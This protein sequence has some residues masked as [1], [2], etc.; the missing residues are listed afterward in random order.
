MQAQAE[1]Q[2]PKITPPSTTLGQL[3]GLEAL[4]SMRQSERR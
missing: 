1:S 4:H 3:R 2:K